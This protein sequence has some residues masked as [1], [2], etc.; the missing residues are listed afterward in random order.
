MN[1]NTFTKGLNQDILPKYQEEGTYRFALNA[2]L[3]NETGSNPSVSNEISNIKCVPDSWPQGSKIIIGSSLTDTDI[4]V[5]FFYDPAGDHEIGLY[6]PTDC[7]YT[8]VIH[9]ACLNFSDKY[10]INAI[11]KIRNGCDRVVYFTDNYNKYRVLNLDNPEATLDGD[12]NLRCDDILYYKNYFKPC[13]FAYRGVNDS[14]VEDNAGGNL[15]VGVY[16]FAV[17]FLDEEYNSTEW[18]IVTRGVA[19]GDEPTADLFNESLINLYDGGSNTE[20][21]PTYVPKT[22][23]A[24][25]LLITGLKDIFP[26]YQ[27]AVIKRTSDSG[28]LSGVDIL[29]PKPFQGFPFGDSVQVPFIYNGNLEQVEREGTIDEILVGR[30]VIEQ[31]A[32]HALKGDRNYLAGTSFDHRDYSKYQQYASKILTEWKKTPTLTSIA[33][34][35]KKPNYYFLEGSFMEDE[36]YAAGIV[37]V[38]SNGRTSP[39]F[40]IPGRAP[41]SPVPGTAYNPLIGS[42]GVPIDGGA[43]WDTGLAN[44]GNYDNPG[45]DNRWKLISTAYSY[46]SAA[47]LEGRMGYYECDTE[48]YPDIATCEDLTDGYWGRDYDG[49]LI[50]PGTTH[51]R[52]HRMPGAEFKD[53]ASEAENNRTAFQFSNVEYPPGEDIVGHYFVYGDRSFS[54][55]IQAKGVFMPLYGLVDYLLAPKEFLAPPFETYDFRDYIF[56]SA[57]TVLHDKIIEGDHIKIEKILRDLNFEDLG[58]AGNEQTNVYS[59]PLGNG[60]AVGDQQQ[61]IRYFT[62]YSIPRK[63]EILR[64]IEQNVKLP[65]SY[66]GATEGTSVLS[67]INGLPIIN[68]SINHSYQYIRLNAA[69][70]IDNE[71]D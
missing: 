1:P 32:A 60:T 12:G 56:I 65:K 8:T 23:K 47:P 3:E 52:H 64:G 24:I 63:D 35:P 40:H 27:V 2:V 22:S 42:S 5:L 66:V 34:T 59:Y 43:A 39:V 30:Q 69:I 46:T 68:N 48:T 26:F 9:G 10:P 55:L 4:T 28:A 62:K 36:V 20:T 71:T 25:S 38:F 17:R 16:Y 49:N 67:P 13:V 11:V 33:S 50:T 21:S 6:N 45:S 41:D 54:K 15:E 31:V 51:I 53:L 61:V 57:E 44:Y 7:S 58:A 14:G 37:Y 29:K 18:T 70:G 19:L